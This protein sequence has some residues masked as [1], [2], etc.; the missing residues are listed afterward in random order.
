MLKE[1][2]TKVEAEHC[3]DLKTEL[4]QYQRAKRTRAI[5]NFRRKI[6]YRLFRIR[7]NQFEFDKGLKKLIE[8]Q[9]KP[10]MNWKT[11]T[12]NW[13]ISANDPLKVVTPYEWKENGGEF[14]TQNVLCDDGIV[15]QKNVCRPFAFTEQD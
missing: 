13:D 10:G 3:L 11:F 4:L 8:A 7:E 15:R 5:H 6:R 14:E 9:F 1:P 12:F 2:L